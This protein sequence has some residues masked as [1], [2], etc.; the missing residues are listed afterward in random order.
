MTPVSN[1]F[2]R[3]EDLRS[4]EPFFP[5]KAL[6]CRGCWLV[7]TL[8]TLGRDTHF[9]GDYAYF[10]SVTKGW[11]EHAQ[12]FVE[13]IVG[14]EGL[15]RESFVVEVASNDGYLLQHFV[16]KGVP[17]LGVDPAA[18]CA[19][20]AAERYGV[21]TEVGFFGREMGAAIARR[22]GPAD[23]IVANNVLAHVPDLNDFVAGFRALLAAR[24]VI[25]FEF[26]HLLRLMEENQFD[27]VYHEHYSYLSALAL[28]PLFA[29]HGLNMVDVEEL[30]THGGS[31]RL[32]LRHDAAGEGASAAMTSLIGREKAARLDRIETYATFN[33]RVEKT[34]RKLL[35]LLIALKNDG[36]RIAG[37]GAP[38][39]GNTLLNYCGIGTDFLDYT[40]DRSEAK[41]GLFLPGTQIPILAPARILE[42]RPD[43]VLILPW[44]IREEIMRDMAG[45]R[46]WGGRFIVPI[47]EPKVL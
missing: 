2:R 8:D 20:A 7:Q 6:V 46:D 15:G 11:V 12:S 21:K 36:K 26:P 47:P 43:Y 24:G 34:K 22:N 35:S 19:K 14:R 25:S 39:K 41:Q 3:R 4:P 1:A 32:F 18:N 45:I 33:A 23:L 29:R 16:A 42:D 10:S 28:A 30:A 31:L 5:L 27:T 38:A 13:A 44:N 40:V 37:Y 9:H 17:C